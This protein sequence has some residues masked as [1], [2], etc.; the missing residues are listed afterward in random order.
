MAFDLF[1]PFREDA[2]A[3]V[4]KK[5]SGEEI[6]E[7][8]GETPSTKDLLLFE[9]GLHHS[10]HNIPKQI[11]KSVVSV[12]T[13]FPD[14]EFEK[15][16][17]LKQ[18][19]DEFLS[20]MEGVGSKILLNNLL[21]EA[22]VEEARRRTG[23]FE[24]TPF[25]DLPQATQGV[26]SAPTRE[27][28]RGLPVL[29]PVRSPFGE[30][31]PSDIALGQD[32][33]IDE[34]GFPIDTQSGANPFAKEIFGS[35][36]GQEVLD[37]FVGQ[38]PRREGVDA[39]GRSTLDALPSE[40]NPLL[41]EELLRSLD[42][43]LSP[44]VTET[45]TERDPSQPLSE[46]EVLQADLALRT[47]LQTPKG[48]AVSGEQQRANLRALSKSFGLP[49][50]TFDDFVVG[51]QP[52]QS[53][54][55]VLRQIGQAQ[56]RTL[57]Q[58]ETS[59]RLSLKHKQ[60]TAERESSQVFKRNMFDHSS[61]VNEKS[62]IRVMTLGNRQK[63]MLEGLETN[64]K[65]ALEELKAKNAIHTQTDRI[66]RNAI[67][68]SDELKIKEAQTYLNNLVD[69]TQQ[70]DKSFYN[71]LLT[72]REG[73]LKESSSRSSSKE[74]LFEKLV[75]Q[76]VRANPGL[77][78]PII[79]FLSELPEESLSRG[80]EMAIRKGVGNTIE[81]FNREQSGVRRVATIL[82]GGDQSLG[83]TFDSPTK[84]INALE[85]ELI[86]PNS[87]ADKDLIRREMSRLELLTINRT[88]EMSPTQQE[89][90]ANAISMLST[91]DRLR[92]TFTPSL[93]GPIKAAIGKT[94]VFT[95][96]VLRSVPGLGGI[97]DLVDLD[98]QAKLFL[99]DSES[100]RKLMINLAGG[101]ALTPAEMELVV[102]TQPV[103]T[104]PNFEVALDVFEANLKNL[105]DARELAIRN[106]NFG[107]LRRSPEVEQLIQQIK[108]RSSRLVNQSRASTPQPFTS[109]EDA[110]R[111]FNRLVTEEHLP[112][113]EAQR[114]V[115]Q[116]G[117][118]K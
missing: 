7:A 85:A 19:Q 93:I 71:H 101:L 117:V 8:L 77:A 27:V 13:G 80:D 46:A 81:Q 18:R 32:A 53:A 64:N 3:S 102:E 6:Q 60:Q 76:S 23:S 70:F 12:I 89:D 34:F 112:E 1:A 52:E 66:A 17:N 88:Q 90:F 116:I 78:S 14:K 38:S 107:R 55:T 42:P 54:N 48:Q 28:E 4:H 37:A 11:D 35:P 50:D 30:A 74:G 105:M 115:N 41:N 49:I 36:L 108:E 59:K 68:T 51:A 24:D 56:G 87:M 31:L 61:Q 65:I 2:E 79:S 82:R 86:D 95:S 58:S 100:F 94:R 43:S 40:V 110:E 15:A 45:I 104:N 98:P 106:A 113:E 97:A 73:L 62:K 44:Q 20:T 84:Q 9:Q 63:I 57:V 103:I 83:E 25:S 29:G 99:G 91:I 16:L 114:R 72:L 67:L 96:N 26:A 33:G 5:F 92:E 118:T 111:E 75:T 47:Q 10:Q 69:G 109:M 39:L 22:A 21:Q